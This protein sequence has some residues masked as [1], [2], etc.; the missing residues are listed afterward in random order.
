MFESLS[1]NVNGY[2]TTIRY[3]KS[4]TAVLWHI[5]K[6]TTVVQQIKAQGFGTLI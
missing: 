2:Y 1:K 6:T 5:Y 3:N 4:F